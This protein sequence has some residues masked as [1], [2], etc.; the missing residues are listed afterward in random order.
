MIGRAQLR[1]RGGAAIVAV[2]ALL[3]GAAAAAGPLPL[4][5]V[6]DVPLPGRPTRFDYQW[7]DSARG[8]LYIA[9]LGDDSIDVV[10]LRSDKVVGVIGGL[11][12]VHGVLAVPERHLVLATVTGDKALALI[13]DRTLVVRARV[14]AG[15]YPNGLAFDSRTARAFV[16]NNEGLGVG[17]VDVERGVALPG[18]DIGGGA[19]NSQYD[20]PSGH[21]F[22]AVHKAAV[23][24]EIDPA[25]ARVVARHPL[26]GV[27]SC[28]GLLVAAEQRLAFAA[29][30][31]EAGPRLVT[32]D[33]A[34]MRQVSAQPIPRQADVLA[35]DPGPRRL[36]VSS[37]TGSCAVF[38]VAAA[39]DRRVMKLG[40]GF[41]GP[42]AHTV[43]VD[44][45]S[46][47]VYFPLESVGGR[48]VL[49]VM[50][51]R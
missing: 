12:R 18:V 44:P 16:S 40:E 6:H 20:P 27:R 37:E 38:E 48:A 41:V 22:V 1:C 14:P 25:A 46:H 11:P 29:C 50:E 19:G 23:L 28:H 49:R 10:D 31:S 51:P 8:R 7:V 21:V 15:E 24:V 4:A 39:G 34:S 2:A 45:Q 9:H 17:V 26:D 13:D 42:D 33:L 3:P 47:R 32:F 36:Y 35:F 30:G 43:S 5:L